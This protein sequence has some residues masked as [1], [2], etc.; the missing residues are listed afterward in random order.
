MGQLKRRR[1]PAAS[2]APPPPTERQPTIRPPT[3]VYERPSLRRRFCAAGA[4]RAALA[5]AAAALYA[6]SCDRRHAQFPEMSVAAIGSARRGAMA[7]DNFPYSEA[8]LCSPDRLEAP[9]VR[10]Q[11]RQRARQLREAEASMAVSTDPDGPRSP[12]TSSWRGGAA[13]GADVSH[14]LSDPHELLT[15]VSDMLR[16]WTCGWDGAH[17]VWIAQHGHA[18]SSASLAINVTINEPGPLG[19]KFELFVADAYSVDAADDEKGGKHVGI[20]ELYPS[21]DGRPLAIARTR[22]VHKWSELVAVDGVRVAGR[23]GS[24]SQLASLMPAPDRRPVTLTFA[25]RRALLQKESAFF[26]LFPRAI[27]APAFAFGRLVVRTVVARKESVSRAP[28]GGGASGGGGASASTSTATS[29]ATS[30]G[31]GGAGAGHFE[32]YECAQLGCAA[33]VCWSL[34]VC[35]HVAVG[36]ARDDA[37]SLA[38]AEAAETRAIEPSNESDDQSARGGSSD[39]DDESGEEKDWGGG[40][41]AKHEHAMRC[42]TSHVLRAWRLSDWATALSPGAFFSR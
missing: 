3:K 6:V 41:D 33:L 25:P 23:V 22:R 42:E 19:A 15:M 1:Q 39:S 5:I 16:A 4:V 9:F 21:A 37:L 34:A 8:W 35:A 30:A 27:L 17:Y 36:I 10:Y 2:V 14:I 38:A 20:I 7:R 24:I 26:P 11:Q 28:D 13:L 29:A 32:W 40:G 12:A 18:P 31:A